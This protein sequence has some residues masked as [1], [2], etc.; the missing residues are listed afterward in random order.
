MQSPEEFF[1]NDTNILCISIGAVGMALLWY[2][3][4][5]APNGI[6]IVMFGLILASA[7]VGFSE[8]FNNSVLATIETPE[9]SG[10]LSGMGYGLGYISGLIALILFLLIPYLFNLNFG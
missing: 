7:M 5:G 9:N 1:S 4:P 8:V 10:W 6:W 3:P 2:S